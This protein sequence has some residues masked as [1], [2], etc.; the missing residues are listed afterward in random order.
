M[1]RHLES[2]TVNRVIS[3]SCLYVLY[4]LLVEG[5]MY[6]NLLSSHFLTYY[7]PFPSNKLGKSMNNLTYFRYN[8]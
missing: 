1:M 5:I 8:R 4:A 2:I 7:I 6:H 3:G